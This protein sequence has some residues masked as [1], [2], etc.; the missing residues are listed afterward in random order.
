M[1][2]G[3][4]LG[5]NS[6]SIW[7]LWGDSSTK[8]ISKYSF[9]WRFCLLFFSSSMN[10]LFSVCLVFVKTS[11]YVL[12]HCALGV[13]GFD[14]EC[15]IFKCIIVITFMNISSAVANGA[16]CYW[17]EVN[18]GSG[19]GLVL[20]ENKSL[21]RTWTHF[22]WDPWLHML[23]LGHNELN[24]D[25]FVVRARHQLFQEVVW[26][27]M[28]PTEVPVSLYIVIRKWRT[29]CLWIQ[30]PHQVGFDKRTAFKLIVA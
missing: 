7:K 26:S 20:S 22:D 6:G 25:I 3:R 10:I 21:L 17:W 19:N 29:T 28:L 2:G 12:T 14:F 23:S 8:M 5:Y 30:R 13:H 4:S 1:R 11:L 24:Y 15:V 27:M 16:G 9:L 18:L